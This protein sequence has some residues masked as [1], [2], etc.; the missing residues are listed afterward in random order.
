M[1][2]LESQIQVE[3]LIIDPGILR[4]VYC[5]RTTTLSNNLVYQKNADHTTAAESCC[6]FL[7]DWET[8]DEMLD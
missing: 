2:T 3:G 6:I 8:R 5:D 4:R 1:S 7:E